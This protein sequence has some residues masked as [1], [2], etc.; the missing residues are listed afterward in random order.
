MTPIDAISA[1]ASFE[2]NTP[3]RMRNSPAKFADPGIASVASATSG[4]SAAQSMYGPETVA[5]A[6]VTC[7]PPP[8]S[9]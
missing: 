6:S 8:P 3:S 7:A 4:D 5:V 1:I 9:P 2:L